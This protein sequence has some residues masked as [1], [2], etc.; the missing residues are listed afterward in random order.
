M[1]EVPLLLAAGMNTNN[2]V[3]QNLLSFHAPPRRQLF[4]F[5]TCTPTCRMPWRLLSGSIAISPHCHIEI[6][7]VGAIWN[8][9]AATTDSKWLQQQVHGPSRASA[10]RPVSGLDCRTC[11][12]FAPHRLWRGSFVPIP[13]FGP[14]PSEHGTTQNVSRTFA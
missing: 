14:L 9:M 8:R 5:K 6:G 4:S 3:W 2:S 7:V 13:L 12:I 10:T 1:R 11:A